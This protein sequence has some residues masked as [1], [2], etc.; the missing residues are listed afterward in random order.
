MKDDNNIAPGILDLLTKQ[1]EARSD[2]TT[3]SVREMADMLGL[4]KT[5]SYWLVNKRFFKTVQISGRT[6]VDIRSFN[7]WYDKQVKYHIVGGRPPGSKL[8]ATSYSAAD[9]G[10]ILGISESYAYELIK[11]ENLPV[12][13]VDYWRRVPKKAFDKWYESQSHFRDKED[14]ERDATAE[15]ASISMPE[16]ARMLGVPRRSIYSLV[17]SKKAGEM[18]EFIEVGGRKRITRESFEKWYAGQDHYT[19]RKALQAGLGPRQRDV[20]ESYPEGYTVRQAAEKYDLSVGMIYK[21]IREG[22]IET[23]QT[24]RMKLLPREAFDSWMETQV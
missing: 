13:T 4:G 16:M 14:R 5:E 10:R 18:L 8:K 3:M 2:K 17:R 1:T 9:I 6:R 15:A 21:W 12:I 24:G 19:R 23:T 7:L 11:R 22:R 20:N